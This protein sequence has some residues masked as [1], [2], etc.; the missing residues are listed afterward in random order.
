MLKVVLILLYS[1]SG[2]VG[3]FAMFHLLC[4]TDAA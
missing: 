1:W 3:V 2:V 4:F